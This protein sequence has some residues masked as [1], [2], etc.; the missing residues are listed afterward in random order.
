MGDTPLDPFRSSD[1]STT[2]TGQQNAGV[3]EAQQGWT[4]APQQP[5]ESSS[6]HLDRVN[7]ANNAKK[8]SN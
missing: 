3:F 8:S 7:A 6:A 5:W 1:G 4:P 2:S